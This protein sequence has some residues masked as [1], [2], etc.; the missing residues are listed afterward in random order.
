MLQTTWLLAE[1]TNE[2][3]PVDDIVFQ[4]LEIQAHDIKECKYCACMVS[5]GQSLGMITIVMMKTNTVWLKQNTKRNA[6]HG[7]YSLQ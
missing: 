7:N 1:K 5:H 3:L 4:R 2:A 6:M